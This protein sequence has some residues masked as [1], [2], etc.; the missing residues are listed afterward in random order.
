MTMHTPQIT[1]I[2]LMSLGVGIALARHSKPRSTHNAYFKI[3]DMCLL[4]WILYCG[5]FFGGAA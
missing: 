1:M 3:I 4:A 2:V 5:G